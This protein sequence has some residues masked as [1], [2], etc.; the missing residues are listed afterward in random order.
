MKSIKKMKNELDSKHKEIIRE[1]NKINELKNNLKSESLSRTDVIKIESDIQ[2]IKATLKGL[3][4][5]MER[6][7]REVYGSWAPRNR[8]G[9][10]D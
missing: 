1:L 9:K 7:T 5:D 10:G 8:T 4:E 2:K 6:M 3:G